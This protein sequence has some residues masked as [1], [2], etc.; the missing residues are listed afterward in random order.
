MATLA[1]LTAAAGASLVA[2]DLQSSSDPFTLSAVVVDRDGNPV[3]DLTARDFKISEN[4]KPVQLESARLRTVGETSA[5]GRA[6]VLVLGAGG[7]DPALTTRVQTIA[8]SFIDAAGPNDHVSVVRYAPRD[9]IQGT[10]ND[11]LM[12]IA[13]FRAGMG[14]PLNQRTNRD[15]LDTVASLSRELMDID[16]PRRAIVFVGSPYVYD[17]VLPQ[18]LE[19]DIAWPQWVRALSTTARANVSVYVLDPH[20]LSGN[21]RINPDGLVAQ[22]GG[23]IFFNRNDI[24]QAMN[25]VWRDASAYYALEYLA[26]PSKRD[27]QNISVTLTRPDL[28]VRARRSR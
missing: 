20:A 28:S 25:V 2:T 14:E 13:E 1:L 26:E 8:R 15:V 12:R 19:Y 9:E 10:R 7:T 24:D 18:R 21:I 27:L 17:V 6:V 5:R 11:M 16:T 4:G 3:R 23:T 22:T